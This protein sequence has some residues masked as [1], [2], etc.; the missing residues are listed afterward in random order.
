MGT[1]PTVGAVMLGL[2]FLGMEV[3]NE[4]PGLKQ[5]QSRPLGFALDMLPFLRAW[6]VGAL[7]VMVASG[8]IGFFGDFAL[9]GLNFFGDGALIVGVGAKGGTAPGSTSQPLSEGGLGVTLL[10]VCWL[11]P[12][13]RSQWFGWLSGVGMGLSAGVAKFAA[14]PLASGVNIAGTWLTGFF[15]G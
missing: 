2:L 13:G 1:G 7:T 4:W 11:F 6:C 8:L 12:R 15:H 5:V 10:L 9:W 14:V 3:R